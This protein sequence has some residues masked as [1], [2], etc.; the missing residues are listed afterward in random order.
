[1]HIEI[2]KYKNRWNTI[3]TQLKRSEFRD[4]F[5]ANIYIGVIITVMSWSI[6]VLFLL[7]AGKLTPLITSTSVNTSIQSLITLIITFILTCTIFSVLCALTA[8]A[9]VRY[10]PRLLGGYLL[11][12]Q[13]FMSYGIMDSIIQGVHDYNNS[14]VITMPCLILM[15]PICFILATPLTYILVMTVVDGVER[16]SKTN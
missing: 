13:A 14:I 2:E 1:M 8:I 4:W 6:R 5:K 3:I 7:C 10:M 12:N 16:R 11:I 9:F 15:F